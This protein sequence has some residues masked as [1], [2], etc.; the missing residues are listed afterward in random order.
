MR[1]AVIGDIHSNAAALDKVIHDIREKDV[2]FIVCTGDLVGYAPFPNEVIDLV[3]R[4]NILS[5]QGNYDKAIGNTEIVCGCDYKDEKQ[6]ELAGLSVMFTNEVITEENR[7]YLRSL[8]SEL[9]LK[10]GELRILVVH[11]S[12]R[13]INE[14]LYED[15]GE[16]VEVTRE[17]KEDILICGHTHKPYYKV[18][19]GKHVINSGSVGKPKHGN[20]NATYVTVEVVENK[21][22]VNIHEVSYDYEKTAKAIEENQILPNEFAQMLRMG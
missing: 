12:P 13:K 7:S 18:I 20:P 16:V 6:V 2:D 5:I 9:G 14:Y 8:P 1:F 15:S 3:R 21:V 11:G 19:N 22:K 17:L 10:A 4:S